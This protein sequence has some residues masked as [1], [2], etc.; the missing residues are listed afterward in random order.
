MG[1]GDEIMATARAKRTHRDQGMRVAISYPDLRP[2]PRHEMWDGLDYIVNGEPADSE[3]I[4]YMK[5]A[6]GCRPYIDYDAIREAAEQADAD[7]AAGGPVASSTLR[8]EILRKAGRWFWKPQPDLVPGEIALT[9][10]ERALA[11]H[12]YVIVGP[13]LR[14]GTTVNKA[15]PWS[16]YQALV[17]M[18]PDVPWAQ[19][20]MP[21]APCLSGIPCFHTPTFRQAC[22]VLSGARAFVGNQ[23]GL[24]HAAAALG[25]P[26]VVI[27]N[28][29]C[30]PAV[31]GYKMHVN[32]SA[33][34][35]LETYP[36]GCGMIERC[37]HCDEAKAQITPSR[38]ASEVE[39][40][41]NG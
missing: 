29:F 9:D 28:G 31:T 15:W 26:G 41:L 21:E 35:D 30:S 2:R 37:G 23:G 3:T 12:G 14:P 18:L 27:W 5:D 16:H 17:D 22:G 19:L 10:A 1:Y 13:T 6:P 7:L 32:L 11:G 25:I 34:V 8:A 33:D 36:L 40:L 39:M 20:G 38:V 4:W 24:Q